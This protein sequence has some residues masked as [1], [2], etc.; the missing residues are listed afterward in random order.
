MRIR[1]YSIKDRLLGVFLAP[2]SARAD[3][4]A[5][6]QLKASMSNPNMAQSGL[7]TNPDDYELYYVGTFDDESGAV[8]PEEHAGG[9]AMPVK[10]GQVDVLVGVPARGAPIP[11]E[12]S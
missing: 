9:K 11:G 5:V 8:F 3:V 10:L 4:E 6:R 2:F 7:V 12:P 1:L